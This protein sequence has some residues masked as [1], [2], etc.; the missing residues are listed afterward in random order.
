MIDIFS[1]RVLFNGIENSKDGI[2]NAIQFNFGLE[3]D[4]RCDSRGIY[5]SH[6]PSNSAELFSDI[7]SL[8]N[9]SKSPIALHIKDLKCTEKIVS[10]LHEYDVKNC[11]LFDSDYDYI[12]ERSTKFDVAFYANSKPQKNTAK[13]FWC[14]EVKEKWYSNQ[15]LEELHNQGKTLYAVSR[16]LVISSSLSEIINDWTRLIE[17][18]FDGICTNFP[19]QLNELLKN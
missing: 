16:E 11:F 9:N 17:L 7:C 4:L 18:G 6:D 1:H 2:L 12:L 5:L 14:D 19:T 13:I 8:L 15:I 10:L 3:L